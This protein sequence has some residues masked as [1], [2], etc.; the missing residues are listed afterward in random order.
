[1][2]AARRDAAL[3]AVARVRGV[4]EQDSRI[5]LQLA[6]RDAAARRLEARRL[7]DR[8]AAS[9]LPER[10]RPGALVVQRLAQGHLGRDATVAELEA[11]AAHRIGAEAR[12]RWEADKARLA[13]VERLLDRRARRRAREAE[14]R[15]AKE[16]DDLTAQRWLRAEEA[17][18]TDEE[19]RG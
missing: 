11:A 15:L 12:S 17:R 8:L 5:G 13:A 9:A 19:R 3:V 16:A 1:M 4:R 6:L 2:S 10:V 14:R 18:C 7:R